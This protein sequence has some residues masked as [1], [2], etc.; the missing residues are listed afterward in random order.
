MLLGLPVTVLSNSFIK[1]HIKLVRIK[2]KQ[3]D[4]NNKNNESNTSLYV[5]I[6][7]T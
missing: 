7:F 6:S 3:L 5:Y 4:P 2:T 1:T